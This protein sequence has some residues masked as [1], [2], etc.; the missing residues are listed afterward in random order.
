MTT[1]TDTRTAE[2]VAGGF[3]QHAS[4]LAADERAVYIDSILAGAVDRATTFIR[5]GRFGRGEYEMVRA[6][7]RVARILGDTEAVERLEQLRYFEV[8]RG[9][10]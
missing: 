9:R 7:L 8:G 3:D 4:H 1:T 10:S 2:I 5:S 6:E